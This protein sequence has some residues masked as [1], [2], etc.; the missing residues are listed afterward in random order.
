MR[1]LF[2]TWDGGGNVLPTLAIARQLRLRGHSVRVLGPRSLRLQVDEAGCA[3]AVY[4][5][6]PNRVASPG[7]APVLGR[8][9]AALLSLELARA[10]PTRAFAGDVLLELERAPA[11]ALV[12]DF[13]LAGAIA[14]GEHAGVPTAALMHTAF[15]LP[16]SSRAPFG[17]ALEP[18]AGP[19]GRLRDAAISALARRLNRRSLHDLNQTRARIG[20]TPVASASDQLLSVRRLLVLTT[21]AFDPPP[22]SLPSNV[23]YI[24]PQLDGSWKREPLDLRTATGGSEP[25]VVV[26]FSS[27]FAAQ[28]VV[29]RVLDALEVL[30]VRVLLTLGPVLAPD[31]LRVP[32]SAA[33]HRFI[34]HERVLPGARL[35]VTHAGLGTVMA[36]LAHGVPLLCIPLK[37]DQFENAA[38]V[39]AAGAGR[40]LGG[41]ARRSSLKRAIV[42]LLNDPRFR[43][44][45]GRMAEAIA[46]HEGRAVQE[47]EA[48]SAPDQR[49]AEPLGSPT[50]VGGPRRA[51]S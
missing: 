13:M 30:P 26:S 12:V 7:G 5:H 21:T 3:F 39:V 15:C 17:P 31:N 19:A 4:A 18:A 44:G 34:P 46:V 48:L 14:A 29:Q 22:A 27:R 43:E 24:G 9:R 41:R 23:R 33:L 25:L 47:L 16:A 40:R 37:N 50:K 28:D 11:D 8:A 35:V 2:A 32:A 20:L 45:A 10:A 6:V 36:A 49:P 38:R 51:R 1:F 42:Q